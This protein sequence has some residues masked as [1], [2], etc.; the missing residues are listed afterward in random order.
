MALPAGPGAGVGVR[1][2]G[3]VARSLQSGVAERALQSVLGVA[4]T[5][6][7]RVGDEVRAK[8]AGIAGLSVIARGSSN[9]YRHTTKSPEQI[10][11]ELG[12]DYLLT[13]TVRW[14]K[15]TGASRV[16][17]SPELVDVSPG[18]APRTP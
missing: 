1:S 2:G 17:V 18:H 14:D 5:L 12:A 3:G 4:E 16:R 15:A 8:L 6:G 13:A 11:R 9:Q 7:V 10:A